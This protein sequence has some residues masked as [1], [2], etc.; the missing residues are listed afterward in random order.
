MPSLPWR[1]LPPFAAV[2]AVPAIL[3][4]RPRTGVLLL[5]L[6]PAIA[7]ACTTFDESLTNLKAGDCVGNPFPDPGQRE[8]E[9]TELEKADCDDPGALLVTKTFEVTGYDKFPGDALLDQ[10]ASDQCGPSDTRLI[11]TK[12]SWEVEGDREIVCFKK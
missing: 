7:V 5:V 8:I 9:V 12:E 4:R 10:L 3:L 2:V 1:L 6:V 11:P